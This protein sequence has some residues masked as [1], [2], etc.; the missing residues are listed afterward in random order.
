MHVQHAAAVGVLPRACQR[1]R[2][3][4]PSPALPHAPTLIG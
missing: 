3:N 4:K 2:A 1:E